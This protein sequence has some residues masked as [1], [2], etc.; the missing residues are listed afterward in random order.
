MTLARSCYEWIRET[1]LTYG[2]KDRGPGPF[3]AYTAEEN[4][5]AE[6]VRG[7]RVP[8]QVAVLIDELDNV[9]LPSLDK[10]KQTSGEAARVRT[11]VLARDA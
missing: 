7:I 10:H 2:A 4:A 3:L 9:L 11:F 8:L 1:T 5:R 6:D